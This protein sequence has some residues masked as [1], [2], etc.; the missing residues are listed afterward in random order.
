MR[1]IRQKIADSA[2]KHSYGFGTDKVAFIFELRS[3]GKLKKLLVDTSRTT[4][5][6]ETIKEAIIAFKRSLP[7]P[8]FP[9]NMRKEFRSLT[10]TT[11]LSYEAK[12]EK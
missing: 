11:L 9:E 3:N 7:F 10:F 2:L 4:A 12:G 5:S 8:P 6:K 1:L